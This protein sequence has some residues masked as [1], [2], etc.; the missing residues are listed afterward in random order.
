[1][2]RYK[3]VKAIILILAGALAAAAGLIFFNKNWPA[4]EATDF[5]KC[6][7]AGNPVIAGYLPRC[8]AK[9]GKVFT[10]LPSGSSAGR[11]PFE[12]ITGEP[13]FDQAEQI[14]SRLEQN[15]DGQFLL[16]DL[17]TAPLDSAY[18]QID[19]KDGKQKLRFKSANR[20]IGAG[21]LELKGETDKAA[22]TVLA[23]QRVYR[24]DGTTE[25]LYVGNFIFHHDHRHWHFEDFIEYELYRLDQGELAATTGKMT[26]CIYD[27]EPISSGFLTQP[28]PGVYTDCESG[29]QGISAGWS[30]IY[31]ADVP[32]QELDLTGLAD[33][34]YAVLARINPDGLIAE[35]NYKNNATISYI[36]ISGDKV[37][38]LPQP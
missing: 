1:M 31:E 19:P 14:R 29:V 3:N 4:A 21:Q 32:G 5:E 33:G 8:L 18:I 24:K 13:A 10:R 27:T 23:S 17:E 16:P 6:A 28:E 22:Q 7:A 38:I 9:D 30:D 35:S 20:N 11:F 12:P 2:G 34:R 36:N 37:I 25:T 26:F 15:Q